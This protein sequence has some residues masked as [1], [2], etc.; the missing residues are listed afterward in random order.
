MAT[1]ITTDC[2]NC[3]ACEPECPN[4]AIYAGAE[5]KGAPHKEATRLWLSFIHSPQ[6][7][8]VFERY[9]F[10]PYTGKASTN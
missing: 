1:V 2:I 7:L 10:K 3:G 8:S 6:A 5:V 9:G 4:T